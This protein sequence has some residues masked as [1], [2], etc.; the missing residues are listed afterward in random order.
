MA[1]QQE[2]RIL[3]IDLAS[4]Q[5]VVQPLSDI[6][7]PAWRGGR[8]LGV[9]LLARSQCFNAEEA[10]LVIAPGSLC[11][12]GITMA[13]R[14]VLTGISPL[15]GG[16]FSCSSGGEFALALQG[17]GL[18]ALLL[19]GKAAGPVMLQLDADGGVT[20]ERADHLWGASLQQMFVGYAAA[21]ALAAIGPAGE[22]GC[23]YADLATRDGEP[24]SR[25]GFGAL[26]GQRKV[27]GIAVA[28]R[29]QRQEAV[30][31]AAFAVAQQDL[32]RL[33]LASPFLFG[34]FGIHRHGTVNLVDLLARRGMLPGRNFGQCEEGAAVCN[35][36]AVHQRYESVASGCGDCTVRCKR[37]ALDGA[38]L[39]GYD[40]L[41]AFT[42]VCGVADPEVAVALCR[43]CRALGLDPVSAAGTLA[44][45]AEIGGHALTPEQL[46][47]LLD[48]IAFGRGE[49]KVLM[50]GAWRLAGQ[51]GRPE[52]AM[53]VKGLELP[54]YDPRAACGLALSYAVAPHG[55]TH[56]AAWTIAAEILR[57]PVPVDPACFDGK[58]RIVALAEEAA[59]ALDSL[60][61]C[62]FISCAAELEEC[63]AVV[64]ALSGISCCA[65]DLLVL[66]R[67]ILQSERMINADCGITP[68]DDDLPQRFFTT[69][70]GLLPPLDRAAFLAELERYRRIRQ[71]QP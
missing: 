12:S 67:Q 21:H 39:P 20:L 3:R 16:I 31:Q 47:G 57:K 65:A 51:L 33:L 45:W 58:A 54:P 60:G 66:G 59:A 48:A 7:G 64:A 34:P 52:A 10:P 41:A 55:G 27:K 56:L 29:Q 61:L 11:G 19:E 68:G 18:A 2:R 24:F 42:G 49:G 13:D 5:A 35:A 22:N 43:R 50:Q 1:Q 28:V 25:G 23:L 32:Q 46:P 6:A 44:A 62:R 37:A 9:E 8:G 38:V 69:G 15:T 17:A 40:E 36:A 53:T 63:A 71:D 4:G 26:L 30:D 70:N 14:A